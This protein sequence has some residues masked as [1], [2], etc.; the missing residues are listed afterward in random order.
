MHAYDKKLGYRAHQ[1]KLDNFDGDEERDGD[2][3]GEEDPECDEEDDDV[4]DGVLVV[5]T[6]V[7]VHGQIPVVVALVLPPHP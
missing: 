1:H 7:Q 3:V 4:D 5:A 2:E 6:G